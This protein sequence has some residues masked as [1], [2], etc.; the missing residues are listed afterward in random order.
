M[1]I[2]IQNDEQVIARLESPPLLITIEGAKPK[3]GPPIYGFP[4]QT[5]C[6]AFDTTTTRNVE[7]LKPVV[8]S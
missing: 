2:I 1:N 6:A 7:L 4:S 8:T 5:V 3:S